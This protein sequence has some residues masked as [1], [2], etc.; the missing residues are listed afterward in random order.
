MAA[1]SQCWFPHH[2]V[3]VQH[4]GVRP[5]DADGGPWHS[6]DEAGGAKAQRV[7]LR[8]HLRALASCLK[9]PANRISAT[10]QF[11]KGQTSRAEI[12]RRAFR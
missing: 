12:E 3:S 8:L 7:A 11:E 2:N 10:P 9:S 1:C 4:L 6:Q 5:H